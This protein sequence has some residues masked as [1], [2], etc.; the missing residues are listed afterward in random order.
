MLTGKGDIF[1]AGMACKQGPAGCGDADT[2]EIQ[3]LMKD[4]P[5]LQ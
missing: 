2:R 1:C 3:I 4:V 5:D